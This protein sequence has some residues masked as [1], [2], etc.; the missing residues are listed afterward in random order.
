MCY[1]KG[2]VIVVHQHSGCW[3]VVVEGERPGSFPIDNL[4]VWPIVDAEG[5]DWIG[6]Q[7]EY[8]DGMMRF[9]DIAPIA[10]PHPPDSLPCPQLLA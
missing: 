10:S 6:R 2:H 8:V 5:A 3:E 9:L 4:C 7:V 1:C